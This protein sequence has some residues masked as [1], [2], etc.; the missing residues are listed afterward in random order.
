MGNKVPLFNLWRGNYQSMWHFDYKSFP[1]NIVKDYKIRS[2]LK[3][4]NK[5]NSWGLAAII[6]S[7]VDSK[8]HIEIKAERPG[9]IIGK[10]G[11]D[12]EYLRGKLEN[13]I[14]DAIKIQVNPVRRPET[15]SQCIADKI[16]FDLSKGKQ[17]KLLIKK[18]MS[19]AMSRPGI[20]GI[21]V[22]CSGRLGGVEIA[23]VF[24]LSYGSVPRKTMRAHIDYAFSASKTNSG[25]CGVKVWV[26]KG[27][28]K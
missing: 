20:K 17:Y 2:F 14:G 11:Q 22:T 3:S 21:S 23:R 25:L 9:V 16:A 24:K 4:V 18:Y 28:L 10:S 12:L 8:T 26:N 1:E 5:S 6:I 7:R 15:D 13:L 27:E 19:H